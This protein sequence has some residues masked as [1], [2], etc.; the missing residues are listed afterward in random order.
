MSAVTVQVFELLV[1]KAVS[2]DKHKL[3]LVYYCRSKVD[4]T[5]FRDRR[6]EKN[7]TNMVNLF[8]TYFSN[9]EVTCDFQIDLLVLP[10]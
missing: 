8:V 7:S 4:R 10:K 1:V 3:S 9:L 5:L 6:D 2:D